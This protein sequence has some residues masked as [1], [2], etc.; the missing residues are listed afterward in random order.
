MRRSQSPRYPGSPEIIQELLDV[1]IIKFKN[2]LD[3]SLN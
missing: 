3:T 1:R 2:T